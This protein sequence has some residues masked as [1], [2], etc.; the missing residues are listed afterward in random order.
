[1]QRV[2]RILDELTP[3]QRAALRGPSRFKALHPGRRGGKSELAGRAAIAYAMTAPPGSPVVLGADTRDKA[4][5]L[6]WWP[7]L[8]VLERHK[9]P[10]NARYQERKIELGDSY[11]KLWGANDAK[12]IGRL[13]GFKPRAAIFDE[14]ASYAPLLPELVE[15]VLE[16]ALGDVRGDL[17]LMGTP[18]HTC[19]GYWW[20]VCT[21]VKPGWEVHH[22]TVLDNPAF[23]RNAAGFLRETLERNQ[24]AEEEPIY[25][26]EYLGRFVHDPEG[27][28]FAYRPECVAGLPDDYDP[29]EWVHVVGVDFGM[30]DE[31]AW[32]VLA[33]HPQ[34]KTVW[35]VYAAK[36]AELLPD[37][38]A[39]RTA[40]LVGRYNVTYIE[41]DP[42]GIGAPYIDEFNRR[43]A[44]KAGIWMSKAD[45]REK[46]AAIE[47]MNGQL[48]G[49]GLKIGG[50]FCAPL[51]GEVEVLPWNDPRTEPDPRY[52]N[53]CADA[54]LYGWRKLHAYLHTA[55]APRRALS[56]DED[57]ARWEH[58]EAIEAEREAQDSWLYD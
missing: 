52:P 48:R 53:H 17:W 14:V 1:M 37:E 2:G 44:S 45:K 26:R 55:P 41:A 7:L 9:I 20:E 18:S 30:R 4:T 11:L 34:R 3:V 28:V 38:V 15:Q 10:H 22:W 49:G 58:Q 56:P 35:T 42:G 46:R 57:M 29:Q 39:R 21:G 6:F 31:T 13:R 47:L 36:E 25:Q 12:Q 16:P 5:D 51:V 43:H 50:H 33:A 24:W 27:L 54:W 40:E 23:P 19:S 8:S 32:V